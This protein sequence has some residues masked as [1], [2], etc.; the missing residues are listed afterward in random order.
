M[1]DVCAA[2][3]RSAIFWLLIAGLGGC[4]TTPPPA[5]PPPSTPV[6]APVEIAAPAPAPPCPSCDEQIREIAR[7]RQSLASR[8]TELRD[9]RSSQRDQVKVLRES[10]REVTRARVRL[11]RLAT[12]A[13]AASSIAEVEVALDSLR[14]S[15]GARSKDPLLVLAHA[16]L[17]STTA[18]FEQGDYG[19]AME[20]AAQADQLIGLVAHYQ[21]PRSRKQPPRE[22]PFEIAI[23]LKVITDSNLRRQPLGN[24]PIVSVLKKDSPLVA[25]AHKGSWMQVKTGDGRTGWINHAQLGAP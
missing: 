21:S 16:I 14:A 2:S 17:E 13:D 9:L 4:V 11:R 8:E 15:L 22:V 20:R 12:Q 18:P 6:P 19:V 25:H 3:R 24:A 23:P 1:M 5:V 7:L 10:S